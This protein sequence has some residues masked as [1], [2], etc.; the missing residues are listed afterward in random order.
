MVNGV[1]KDKT[2]YRY[3]PELGFLSGADELLGNQLTFGYNHRFILSSIGRPGLVSES[4]SYDDG[5]R[6]LSNS[7]MGPQGTLRSASLTYDVRDKLIRTVAGLDT[8][9]AS[10]DGFGQY[11]MAPRCRTAARSGRVHG[12]VREQRERRA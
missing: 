8:L 5:G 7:V 12:A 9:T 11:G 6:L 4:Y 10:Y 2:L 3:D 1:R